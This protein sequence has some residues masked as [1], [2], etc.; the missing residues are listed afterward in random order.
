[1]GALVAYADFLEPVPRDEFDVARQTMQGLAIDALDRL[2]QK[3]FTAAEIGD[4][5]LPQRTLKHRKAKGQRLSAEE[6]ER[7][8]RVL[9]V[10]AFADR[11]FGDHEK[12]MRWLRSASTRLGDASPLSTLRTEA[13]GRFVEGM[14]WAISEN[15]FQ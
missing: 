8:L 4:I 10:V 1:M 5:V 3:G 11:V 2:R 12:A 14:L 13:G 7:L 9:R 15:I 6:S